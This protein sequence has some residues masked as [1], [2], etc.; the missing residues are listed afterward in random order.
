VTEHICATAMCDAILL[1]L[2]PLMV[3]STR[4]L[5]QHEVAIK[6]SDSCGVRTHALSDWR[7]EPAP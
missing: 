5:N 2:G 1:S 4:L 7:L 6:S 3:P